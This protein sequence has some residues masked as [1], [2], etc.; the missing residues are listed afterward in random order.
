MTLYDLLDFC[1]INNFDA[2]DLTGYYFPGYPNV[3]AD[4]YIYALKRKA[5][6]LGLDISGTGIKNDFTT[7][8][9]NK[10]KEDITLAKRWIETA[11]KLGA[12]VIR[13]FSG[14]QL[15]TG[16]TWDQAMTWMVK[17]I[18]ECVAYGKQHGVIVAVQNHNDFIKT[19]D[20]ALK[21]IE[22]V[23]S[24]WFGLVLDVGSY[25]TGDPF[26]QI[27]QTAK[28][29]VNWQLKENMYINQTEGKTDLR[30]VI[31]IIK[32]SGYRGYV[33]IETLGAGD[34]KIKVPQ[35]LAEVRKEMERA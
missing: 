23:N 19:A 29:A 12:P 22:A 24:E 33:P 11:E 1:A 7:P 28:F 18:N 26:K 3:P 9:E 35:F 15:P 5:F 17:D 21:I 32:A 30:K 10:R 16:Y 13:I 31:G 2:V 6:L 4:D 8:D 34:P 25:R 14:T 20:E 27:E